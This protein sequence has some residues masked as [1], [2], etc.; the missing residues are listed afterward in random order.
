MKGSKNILNIKYISVDLGPERGINSE[1]TFKDVIPYLIKNGF[2]IQE[3]SQKD[4]HFFFITQLLMIKVNIIMS[5]YNSLPT[6]SSCL[7]SIFS[8]SYK[9]C[10]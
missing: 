6:L 2:I 5:V 4:T 8:Q 7:N 3:I 9:D 1:P 10:K